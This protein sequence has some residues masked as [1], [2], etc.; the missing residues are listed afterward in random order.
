MNGLKKILL[1]EPTIYTLI[2]CLYYL[3]GTLY[4][5]GNGIAKILLIVFLVMSLINTKKCFSF[6]TN[7]YMRSIAS[8]A[9]FFGIYGVLR[10]VIGD[11]SSWLYTNDPTTYLKEYEL[12]ILPIFSFYY[13][14]RTNKIDGDWF[15]FSSFVFLFVALSL[16]YREQA[17]RLAVTWRDEVTNNTGYK[18]LALL[19]LVVFLKK[20]PLLQFAFLAIVVVYILQGMKRGA[21][22]VA[23]IS[24]FFLLPDMFRSV[25]GRQKFVV[26]MLTLGILVGGFYYITNIMMSSE[27][28]MVRIDQTLNGD[29]SNREDMYPM[30]FRHFTE[31]YDVFSKIFGSGADSTLRYMGD[32]AHNDWLELLL[33]EGILGIIIYVIYWLNGVR[34]FWKK[35]VHIPIEISSILGITLL[36]YFTRSFFSMSIN[37]MPLFTTSALGYAIAKKDMILRSL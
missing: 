12:S 28:F 2:W 11:D 24:L 37:D 4:A 36:A 1:Q 23:A 13:Y 32:F 19:P 29:A 27:Y 16:F 5:E 30:Y 22:V 17:N 31:R 7:P 34:Y 21:I 20:R 6:T 10:V 25:K 35:R 15:Y 9:I 8:L 3:Q 33:D 26:T 14:T 18:F